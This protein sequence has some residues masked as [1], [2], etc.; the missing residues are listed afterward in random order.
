MT[1]PGRL[2]AQQRFEHGRLSRVGLRIYGNGALARATEVN[3]E[4]ATRGRGSVVLRLPGQYLSNSSAEFLAQ[5]GGFFLGGKE[6][7]LSEVSPRGIVCVMPYATCDSA[8][9]S[10]TAW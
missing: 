6:P 4:A 10:R 7:T 9:E 1:A 5:L 2:S 8:P 3:L